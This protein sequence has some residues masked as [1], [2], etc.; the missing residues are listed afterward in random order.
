MEREL[1][2]YLMELEHLLQTYEGGED[3]HARDTLQGLKEILTS[4]ARA[5]RT[6][7][8]LEEILRRDTPVTVK[9]VYPMMWLKWGA[10]PKCGC[11][12][13]DLPDELFCSRCGTK[14]QFEAEK[15]PSKYLD[16]SEELDVYLKEAKYLRLPP[17]EAKKIEG[18]I[19]VGKSGSAQE[20]GR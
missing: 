2:E 5:A 20:A 6:L 18:R 16:L 14:I 15:T 3:A 17:Q 13:Y 19:T 7:P 12:V 11:T 10:C 1:K 8:E 9:A 4:C